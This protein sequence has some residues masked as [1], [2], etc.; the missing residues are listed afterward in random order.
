MLTGESR[1]RLSKKERLGVC[2]Q[3]CKAYFV[4]NILV[5]VAHRDK[6]RLAEKL[7]QIWLQPDRQSAERL[8]GLIIEKYKGK[9]PEAMRC[10]E[11]GVEDSLKFHN[12]SEIDKRRISSTNILERTAREIRRRSR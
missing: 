8:A 1:R 10:L 12:F 9:Y 4:R 11:E 7:N 6:A 3:R 5:K 2:W